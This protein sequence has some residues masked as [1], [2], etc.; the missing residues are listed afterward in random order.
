[1]GNL[2]KF[3]VCLAKMGVV[4]KVPRVAPM[5]EGG[6]KTLNKLKMMETIKVYN[7]STG[8]DRGFSRGERANFQKYSN[9]CKLSFQFDQIG[10][11]IFPRSI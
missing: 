3:P 1:M 7:L 9:F 6:H 4:E 11:L 5:S 2:G 10:F 8:A